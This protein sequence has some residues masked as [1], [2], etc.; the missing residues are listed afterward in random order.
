MVSPLHKIRRGYRFAAISLV[1]GMLLVSGCATKQ[2]VLQVDEKVNQVRN[3]QRLLKARVDHIDSLITANVGQSDQSRME[4][5]ASLDDMATQ[6]GQIQ[7]QLDD[8]QQIVYTMSQRA[9]GGTMMQQ[10]PATTTGPG[11]TTSVDTTGMQAPTV[12]CRRLWDDAFKDMRAGQ[13]DLA[14]SGFSDYLKYCPGGDLSDNSQYWIAE[15]YYEMHQYEQAIEEYN[16]LLQQYP[17]TEKK[18]TAYFK[19]G[20][21]YEELGNKKKA[22]EYYLVLKNEFPGSLEF[23]QV[24]DKIDAWQKEGIK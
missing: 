24:K 2:D 1:L 4:I 19:L 16:K 5:K 10:Q 21:S 18:K 11:D 17:Q 3:D 7:R 9:G 6:L 8:L 22:L 12:D 23:E 20:R 15:A 13:Y 14:I